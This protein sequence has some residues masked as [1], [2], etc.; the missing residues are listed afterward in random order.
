MSALTFVFPIAV[1]LLIGFLLLHLELPKKENLTPRRGRFGA[2]G[3]AVITLVYGVTAFVGLGD[4]SAPQTFFAPVGGERVT[5][6]FAQPE[7]ISRVM[8]YAGIGTG[9]W[10]VVSD[11]SGTVLCTLPQE[12]KDVLKWYETA[13]EEGT[14][15][16]VSAVT[17]YGNSTG[18]QMGEIAFFRPDGSRIEGMTSTD[19]AVI[20]EQSLVP[21]EPTYKNSTYFDEIYHARTAQEHLTGV[22]PYE[23]SHPPLGKLILSLGITLFGLTP[24]GWRFMGVLFGVLMVPV[25]WRL[26]KELF[27]DDRIALCV[28]AVFAFDF[29][30]FTQT[31]IATIDTYAVFFI[32]LMYLFMWRWMRG[33]RLLDLGLSGLFFGLGAASKW[34]CLYAGAGLGVLWLLHWIAA[35]VRAHTAP[36]INRKKQDDALA[37]QKRAYWSALGSNILFC[38]GMFVALPALIYYLS[39][40]PYGTAKGLRGIGM[41]FSKEY[42][43][44]VWE[45]QKFMFTYHA[46]LV[47]THPY[48]APWW[49]W[50]LDI[51]PILYYLRYG[52]GTVT[53][54]AAFVN[55][56]LCWGGLASIVV[57]AVYAL[58]R[59]EARDNRAVFIVIG[60]LAQLLPWVFISRITFEYHYFACTVFLALALGYLFDQLRERRQM[61]LVYVCTGL[62]VFLFA[63]FYPALAGIEVTR[64]FSTHFLKWL[65]S[66]PL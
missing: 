32:L 23:I 53:S 48:S 63:L 57:C 21:E 46:G 44:T 42:F 4:T 55:P 18:A 20:D 7:Q 17:V 12:Y 47:S 37:D 15:T 11:D 62:C 1:I 24:F 60:Y 49:K 9:S 64:T 59:G 10:T 16:P 2:I 27:E 61:R 14:E 30:H 38:L 34:T 28:T 33:G 29:M 58:R 65:P 6:T 26:V 13:P 25:M 43:S 51:R 36:K 5:I 41:Y 35:G 52:E 39:Y 56:V 19:E 8:F 66:W 40:T 31:R 45:N 3:A 54:I 22:K 50:L